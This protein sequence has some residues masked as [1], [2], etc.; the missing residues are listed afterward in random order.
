MLGTLFLTQAVGIS[1]GFMG[2][3]IATTSPDEF[4]RMREGK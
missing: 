4:R 2:A 3:A 1:L